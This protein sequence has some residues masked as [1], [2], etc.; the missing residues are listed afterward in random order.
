MTAVMTAFEEPEVLAT[1]DR[2]FGDK[3]ERL[4]LERGE[5]KGRDTFALRVCWLAQDG[6]WRWSAQKPSESGKVWQKLNLKARELRELGEALIAA[7][8][9][10]SETPATQRRA[11][12]DTAAR[13]AARDEFDRN[14]PKYDG[15]GHGPD[16]PF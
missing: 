13:K 6:S 14:H 5:F 1:F 9:T 8:A 15:P 7:A 11:M 4:Q 16:M 10:V 2:S 12:K 3:K